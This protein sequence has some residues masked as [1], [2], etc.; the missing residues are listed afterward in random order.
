MLLKSLL[1]QGAENFCG[2]RKVLGHFGRDSGLA[3][4]VFFGLLGQSFEHLSR[5]LVLTVEFLALVQARALIGRQVLVLCLSYVAEDGE[6]LALG[7]RGR[8]AQALANEGV[9][10][11]ALDIRSFLERL[12]LLGLSLNSALIIVGVLLR[13][14]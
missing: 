12:S 13:E 3:D 14:V 7:G 1:D 11:E 9:E 4:Q 6:A 5:A 10:V 2:I 8:D